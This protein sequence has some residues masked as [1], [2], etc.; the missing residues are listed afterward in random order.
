MKEKK[1]SDVSRKRGRPRSDLSQLKA[2]ILSALHVHGPQTLAALSVFAR[3]YA[4][5]R[6][7]RELAEMGKVKVS[8]WE[9]TLCKPEWTP[10][11]RVEKRRGHPVEWETAEKIVALLR[12]EK[13]MKKHSVADIADSLGLPYHTVYRGMKKLLAEGVV[14]YSPRPMVRLARDSDDE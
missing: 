10:P 2:Q 9:V 8:G 6:A 1:K 14:K 7:V 12:D 3:Y 13:E 4:V 5:R 11:A